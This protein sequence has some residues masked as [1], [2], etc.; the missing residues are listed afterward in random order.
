MVCRRFGTLYQFH[1]QG[2]D[3]PK[4]IHTIFNT[5]R[6]FEIKKILYLL[7]LAPLLFGPLFIAS[8]VYMKDTPLNFYTFEEQIL[9]NHYSFL[10]F[11]SSGTYVN[12][13]NVFAPFSGGHFN[14]WTFSIGPNNMEAD[15]CLNSELPFKLAVSARPSHC[16]P[17]LL[18]PKPTRFL[19]SKC[20]SPALKCHFMAQV[21][22]TKVLGRHCFHFRSIF[23]CKYWQR[24]GSNGSCF[25]QLSHH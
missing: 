13:V 20:L 1:L 21:K 24:C 16:V 17:S 7:M 14:S 9:P 10:G 23:I 2:L 19:H 22:Y 25:Y 11:L 4:R 15:Q 3:V 5:R 18:L 8:P 6:K 12:E